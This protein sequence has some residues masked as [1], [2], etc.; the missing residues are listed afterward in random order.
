MTTQPQDHS[1]L[2]PQQKLIVEYLGQGRT[3]TVK[4][5]ISFLNINSFTK[6][7]TELRKA[8]FTIVTEMETGADGRTFKKYS[9]PTRDTA[10]S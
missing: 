7:I 2:T 10:Q 8:G 4:G 1:G 6:R 3:L 9:F 5:A